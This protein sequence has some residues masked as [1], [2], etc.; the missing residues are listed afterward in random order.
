MKKIIF[1]FLLT[2]YFCKVFSQSGSISISTLN[3]TTDLTQKTNLVFY[4][5]LG[6]EMM[7]S[8]LQSNISTFDI[9][10]FSN[11]IYFIKVITHKSQNIERLII[12]K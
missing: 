2:F 4:N 1:G 9:S 8:N 10:S 6:Q 5:Y 12:Q 3:Y 7:Q 11:G